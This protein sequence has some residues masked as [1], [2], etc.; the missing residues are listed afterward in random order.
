MVQIEGD[1]RV[2][3]LRQINVKQSKHKEEHRKPMYSTI[4]GEEKTNSL[5][6]FGTTERLLDDNVLTY[7]RKGMSANPGRITTTK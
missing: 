5:G 2:Q 3:P 6:D 4:Q 7:A 1:R